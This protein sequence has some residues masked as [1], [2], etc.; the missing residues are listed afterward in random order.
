[1][2][3]LWKSLLVRVVMAEVKNGDRFG[4]LVVLEEIGLRPY[5]EGHNRMWYKC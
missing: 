5:S 2:V 1:M 3:S 4:K